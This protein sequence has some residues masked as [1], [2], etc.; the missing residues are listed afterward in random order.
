M[1]R[2]L[3]A[4]IAASL[5]FAMPSVAANGGQV[6]QG[7]GAPFEQRKAEFLSRIDQRLA[8]LQEARACVSGATTP[9]ALRACLPRHGGATGNGGQGHQ[10][11]GK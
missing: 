11:T 10:K 8:R 4:V 3:F 5:L 1:K 9:E 7:S 2:T 6:G